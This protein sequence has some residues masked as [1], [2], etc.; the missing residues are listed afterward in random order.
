MAMFAC[1]IEVFNGDLDGIYAL[2]QL[3][4]G[5]CIRYFDHHQSGVISNHLGARCI[6]GVFGNRLAIESPIQAH[7]VLTAKA[8]GGYVVS[9]RA[10]RI[11]SSGADEVCSQL[12][13]GERRGAAGINHLPES[14]LNRFMTVFYTTFS[15]CS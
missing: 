3:W 9:V 10:P 1:G 11:A 7:V 8:E 5:A 6:S 14:G 2:H 4:Q 13:T 12:E 15:R